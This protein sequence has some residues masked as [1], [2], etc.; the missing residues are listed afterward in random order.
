MSL[1]RQLRRA[2]SSI[3]APDPAPSP[4]DDHAPPAPRSRSSPGTSSPMA[5][6]ERTPRSAMRSCR[7][8][9]TCA[10]LGR[11]VK[12]CAVCGTA[13]ASQALVTPSRAR[14]RAG[15]ASSGRGARTSDDQRATS[16]GGV[17]ARGDRR[18]RRADPARRARA[19]SLRRSRAA[20]RRLCDR[21]GA[22]FTATDIEEWPGADPRVALGDAADAADLSGAAVHGRHVADVRQQAPQRLRQ[23]RA[24]ADDAA[25]RP[26]RLRDLARPPDCTPATRRG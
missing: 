18:A 10:E 16:S 8:G 24:A 12:N 1:I 14:R 15:S 4:H 20:S 26:A 22:T 23:G 25:A 17:L 3:V 19:R 7:C 6:P 21:L 13:F 9:T 5:P 2:R 11:W